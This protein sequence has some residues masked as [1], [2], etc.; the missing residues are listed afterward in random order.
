MWPFQILTALPGHR[1]EAV[2]F[3]PIHISALP[4]KWAITP[5]PGSF[6]P[7]CDVL[8]IVQEAGWAPG[9]VWRART[10][11]HRVSIPGPSSPWRVAVPTE[12]SRPPCAGSAVKGVKVV[13]LFVT[14]VV[15]TE[16]H[17]IQSVLFEG[18]EWRVSNPTDLHVMLQKYLKNKS[19]CFRV[20]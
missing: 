10:R 8:P 6:T 18:A 9:P 7:E 2:Y 14:C 5:R 1:W 11:P 20:K 17:R 19:T 12:L 3:Q 13:G 4:R 15:R 16:F